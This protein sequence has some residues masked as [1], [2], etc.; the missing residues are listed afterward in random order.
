LETAF[1]E[2]MTKPALLL[3]ALVLVCAALSA[4]D[5]KPADLAGKW[6]ADN[7]IGAPRV[8]VFEVRG[9]K[10]SGVT[11]GPCDAA[12]VFVIEDG[13]VTGDKIKF[14]IVHE[15]RGEGL[16]KYGPYRDVVTGI[17]D[18]N[19]IRAQWHREGGSENEAPHGD[20]A[21]IGPLRLQAK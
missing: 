9:D 5:I 6:I 16:A 11:C 18:G 8:F 13:S 10:I 2:A 7:G 17:V 1:K 3:T 21:L 20:M 19:E 15:D 4:D 12:H 14:Y